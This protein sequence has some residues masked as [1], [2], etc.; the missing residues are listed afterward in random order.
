MIPG[1]SVDRHHWVP[2]S[3]GGTDMV[4]LH[5]VCHQKIHSVLSEKEIARGFSTPE[6]LRTHPQI[7]AFLRWVARK[8]PEFM[9]RHR[10][11]IGRRK[12]R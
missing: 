7:I 8:P 3:Q 9:G 10:P 1:A 5:R 6:S 4:F 11:P 2:K 12:R